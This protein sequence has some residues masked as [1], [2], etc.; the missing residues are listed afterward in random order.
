MHRQAF[1]PTP[2]A[3]R[4][5]RFRTRVVP[6]LLFVAVV[7]CCGK[8]WVSRF[9]SGQPPRRRIVCA[10]ITSPVSGKVAELNVKPLE[11]VCAGRVIARILATDPQILQAT[12]RTIQSEI[13]VLRLRAEAV[14][15]C[16]SARL[17]LDAMEQQV[18]SLM[19]RAML[20]PI[21]GPEKEPARLERDPTAPPPDEIQDA[22]L[23][24][25]RKLEVK[26]R[27]A[28]LELIPVEL[29]ADCAGRI[30]AI[31]RRSGER[32]VAGQR[33][34]TVV[35]IAP[36]C[37][38]PVHELTGSGQ[39]VPHQSAAGAAGVSRLLAPPPS[40]P[41]SAPATVHRSAQASL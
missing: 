20:Q 8:I 18:E 38:K 13:S 21:T 36:H 27:Q 40:G 17:R 33:V 6:L 11:R 26:L 15:G 23:A 2:A 7:A 10:D 9:A 28:E 35:V 14:A 5:W 39:A 31:H 16:A 30:T 12:L 1:I 24:A 34:V 37:T 3:Q 25:I 41:R 4:W 29:K 22:L 19:A 32:I